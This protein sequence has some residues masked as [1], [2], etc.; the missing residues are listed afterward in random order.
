MDNSTLM[1]DNKSKLHF[2]AIH[3][4]SDDK[5]SI[6]EK[7]KNEFISYGLYNDLPNQLIS[8]YQNS[9][10]HNTCVNAIIEGVIGQGL[11]S[12]KPEILKQAN[13]EGE[14]WNDIFT[15][16]VRDYKMFGGFALEVIW[17]KDRSKIAEVYHIDFS[18][19]RAKKKNFRGKIPG[20][21]ISDEWK[22]VSTFYTRDLEEIPYLPIFNPL[23]N[24]Q[25]PNQIYVHQ[26]Y[27]PGMKY[28]PLPDYVGAL[29][30]ID[31]DTEVDNFHINNIKNG[32]APSLS[33]TTFT[34][35]NEEER[36]EILRMLEEQYAGSSNAGSLVYMDVDDPKNA[37]IITPI[38]QNNSDGYYITINEMVSQK[39]LTAHRITS[40]LLLGIKTAGQL[41]AKQE[42]V[43][44]YLLLTNTVLKPY[45]R[46]IIDC[47]TYILGFNYDNFKLGVQQIKL[48]NDGTEVNDVTSG[49]DAETNVSLDLQKQIE[50]SDVINE[51]QANQL[52][53][54]Y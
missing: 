27:Q 13:T 6:S 36:S 43:D 16:V 51:T 18:Y 49:L 12:D 8:L 35:A 10:I 25:E 19:L 14:T 1:M 46:S 53:N 29:K 50:K 32:L 52:N 33:I 23:K 37:P 2:K 15:K 4:F 5:Y 42:M 48:F 21:Y 30:V 31:L 41:G 3:K 39:I 7:D 44:A 34:N 9:S 22:Q 28:Y 17:T 54:E 47:F 24:K 45:Q 26:P 11:I 38:E 40:P 20:Y